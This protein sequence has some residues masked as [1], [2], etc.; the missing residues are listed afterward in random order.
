M[1]GK[2]TAFILRTAPAGDE[3]LL[4]KHPYAGIQI[5]AG[6][7]EP[8][9]TPEIAVRREAAEETGL[10][11]FASVQALGYRPESLPADRRMIR[12]PTTLY[13]RPDM[14][15]TY[16]LEF[17]SGITVRVEREVGT[18]SQISYEEWDQI[19]TPSYVSYRIT[20][21]TPTANLISQWRRHFF[22][23]R[24]DR[25]TPERWQVETDNHRFTLFWAPLNA[26]PT[27]VAPQAVWLDMLPQEFR[28]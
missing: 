17:R 9:E 22:L 10:T 15:H 7:I 19:E 23:L 26:L 13:T 21:W 12:R 24:Y 5:P 1:L 20:G 4:F 6:T 8:D 3:L 25:E 11:A 18:L 16:G 27:I 28:Q 2:V 14:A